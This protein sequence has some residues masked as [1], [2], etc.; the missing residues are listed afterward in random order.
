MTY[1]ESKK[2]NWWNRL[3]ELKKD[4]IGISK[5]EEEEEEADKLFR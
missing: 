2:R 4:V 1:M 3:K 5:E